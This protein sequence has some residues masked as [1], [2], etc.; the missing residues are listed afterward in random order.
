MVAVLKPQRRGV[1]NLAQ[2]VLFFSPF[3][4]IVHMVLLTMTDICNL[5]SFSSWFIMSGFFSVW[6]ALH[7]FLLGLP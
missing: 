4:Y 1:S 6:L 2:S 3:F 5:F 7:W